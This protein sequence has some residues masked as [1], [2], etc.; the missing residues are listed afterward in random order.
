MTAVAFLALALAVTVQ[1]VRLQQA[2]V[3]EQRLRAEAEFH[4]AQVERDLYLEPGGLFVN[5]EI[6][7]RGFGH[8]YVKYPF[9][10]MEDFRAAERSARE[11]RLG[12]WGPDRPAA[13]PS[14]DT[15][16]YITRTGN[17]YHRA[18]CRFLAR[19]ATPI[20]LAEVGGK[21]QPCAACDP[22]RLP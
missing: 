12:L 7:A 20:R 4:R 6:V 16:V 11:K 10:H 3:R 15:V 1:S 14:T 2:L 9:R 19:G 22:P 21:Y 5:R 8:A 17:R 13:A 18:G